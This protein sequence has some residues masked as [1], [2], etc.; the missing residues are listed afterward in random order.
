MPARWQLIRNDARNDIDATGRVGLAAATTPD[1]RA[2]PVRVA[3]DG[4]SVRRLAGP[5]ASPPSRSTRRR[6]ASAPRLVDVE[7]IA[8]GR[9]AATVSWTVDVPAKGFVR[10]GKDSK[11]GRRTKGEDSFDYMTHVQKLEDLTPGTVYHYAVVSTDADG[12]RV[13]SRDRKF[14]TLGA[15][16]KPDEGSPPPAEGEAT[17]PPTTPG[18]PTPPPEATPQPDTTPPTISGLDALELGATFIRVTWTVDEPATGFVQYGRTNEYGERTPGEDSFDYTTHVQ[19]VSGLEPDTTYHLRVVSEDRAGNRAFSGD[20][21]FHTAAAP[22]EPAPDPTP[23]PTPRPAETATPTLAAT[24]AP[25]DTTAPLVSDLAATDVTSTSARISWALDEP[26]TGHVEFGLTKDYGQRTAGEDSFDH[27]RH[28]QSLSGLT[29][30]STYHYRVISTDAAGNRAVSGDQVFT[31]APLAAS[32]TPSAQ[33]TPTPT[34]TATPAPTPRPTPTP[35][36]RPTEPPATPTPTPA[37]PAGAPLSESVYGPGVALTDKSNRQIRTGAHA[38]RFKA[39][40]G[41]QVRDI[42]FQMTNRTS[43]YG[44]GDGGRYRVGIQS[45]NGQGFPTGTWLGDTTVWDPVIVTSPQNN[46]VGVRLPSGPTLERGQ[47]YAVVIENIHADPENNWTS[48]NVPWLSGH[49][50]RTPLWPIF[51]DDDTVF[52]D[53]ARPYRTPFS[54]AV[55]ASHL[56]AFDVEYANGQ[57]EGIGGMRG[58]EQSDRVG[59]VSSSSVATWSFTVVESTSLQ[60][61]AVNFWMWAQSGSANASVRVVSGG[62]VLA[63]GTFGSSGGMADGSRGWQRAVLSTPVTLSP[64]KSYRVEVSTTAGTYWLPLVLWQDAGSATNPDRMRSFP[65]ESGSNPHRADDSGGAVWSAWYAHTT[66][67]SYFEVR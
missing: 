28:A 25:V 33:P 50:G 32:P 58:V 54:W 57:H 66:Y 19:R 23:E 38:F 55:N 31:T 40:H 30:A 46:P 22:A 16:P 42:R 48:I 12:Q 43:P 61:D 41:G 4:L 15:P 6:V 2:V 7:T 21:I 51:G 26:A 24:A 44:G 3:F 56:P 36:P 14:K 47:V 52:L 63:T 1:G 35:T 11:Y 53:G 39:R 49:S 34:A 13:V 59:I 62:Q 17:A 18:D 65:Y 64:G 8:I 45:V 20:H 29:P 37:A 9:T 27:T 5:S 10:F 60:V 67:G